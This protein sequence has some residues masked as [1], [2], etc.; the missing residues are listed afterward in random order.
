MDN[1]TRRIPAG[2]ACD[3]RQVD[4]TIAMLQEQRD[5]TEQPED[6]KEIHANLLDEMSRRDGLYRAL[7]IAA[8][9]IGVG[10]A[11]MAA[12][13]AEAMAQKLTAEPRREASERGYR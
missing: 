4:G 2:I 1:T 7:R 6:R 3:V 9:V 11:E 13:A 8:D 12:I 5:M 10:A